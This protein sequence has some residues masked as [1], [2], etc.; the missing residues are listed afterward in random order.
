MCMKQSRQARTPSAYVDF[1]Q[2][3]KSEHI[4]DKKVISFKE[5][6]TVID[7]ANSH[8]GK[9]HG[10]AMSKGGLGQKRWSWPRIRGSSS[11]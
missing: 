1:R 4:P 2:S 11:R 9:H 10:G 3:Q 5:T 6:I 8:R 7:Y